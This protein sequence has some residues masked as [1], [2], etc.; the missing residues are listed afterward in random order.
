MSIRVIRFAL[1]VAAV[2]AMSVSAAAS[3]PSSPPATSEDC[4]ACHGDAG[5]R[6]A[7]GR[8]IAVDAARVAAS[9]HAPLGCVDCHA[10][11]GKEL[12]H[13]DRLAKVACGSC[14]DDVAGKYHDSIHAWAKEKAGLVGA[15]SCADCHG[16]HDVAPHTAA[17][18]RVYRDR[19]PAT[20]G[21]CHAGVREKYDAGVHAA[22]L[23]NG[24]SNAPVC[25]DCHAA[26]ATA[27]TDT[28]AWRLRVTGECGTCHANIVGSYRR[29][30]HGKA[31]SLGSARVAACADCHGAHDIRTAADTTST[32]SNARLVET[33][34]RCHQ[35]ATAKFV[36]YD[37][38]PDPSDY[39]RGAVLWWANR[40]YW[41]LIPGCFGFFGL[42][43][44]L[45]YWRSSHDGERS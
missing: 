44:A 1:V 3:G 39:S 20:C 42:H 4:V 30:F 13:P 12:P 45:W 8:S 10:E 32:V 34:G 37:P 23:K 36:Q 38:H 2:C 22:A 5:A 29:T 19:V 11:A 31:T 14:H 25:I 40:F 7:D 41:L 28:D 35:G 43:S 21:A 15:P 6:R 33:C 16:T 27:R 17:T 24:A 26:H 18:S 9:I